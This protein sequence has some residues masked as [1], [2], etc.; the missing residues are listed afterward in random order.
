MRVIAFN[1]SPRMEKG[2]TD[3]VL[4]RF[5]DGVREAGGDVEKIYVRKMVI[6]GCDGCLTCWAETPGGCKFKDDMAGVLEKMREADVWVFATPIY[7]DTMT[8]YMKTLI[9]RMLPLLAP[10]MEE[11]GR[12]TIHPLRYPE[13]EGRHRMV[14]ISVC[15]FPEKTHFKPLSYTFRRISTNFHAPIAA[16]IYIPGGPMLLSERWRKRMRRVLEAVTQAGREIATTGEVSKK[17]LET[18]RRMRIPTALYRD[19]IN[20]WWR[21]KLSGSA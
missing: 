19:I 5:L 18:I 10:Y 12:R 16:E 4:D 20:R 11:C 8:S 1:G 3:L 14:I 15:G 6:H 7:C 21:R 9:E 17:T 2:A 13:E